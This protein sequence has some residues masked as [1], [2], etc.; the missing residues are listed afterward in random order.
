MLAMAFIRGGE[1]LAAGI[2]RKVQLDRILTFLLN[3][4]IM[5]VKDDK[6]QAS[7]AKTVMEALRLGP[8][9]ATLFS[10]AAGDCGQV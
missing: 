5:A 6:T 10:I 1:I 3:P 8:V 2:L 4:F 7:D 9:D